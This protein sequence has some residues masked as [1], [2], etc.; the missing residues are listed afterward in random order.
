MR[1]DGKIQ[2]GVTLI[3]WKMGWSLLRVAIL[4]STYV[5]VL[6]PSNLAGGLVITESLKRPKVSNL[7]LCLGAKNI[8][9]NLFN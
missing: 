1:S 3:L 6:E 7:N 2:D 5:D 4:A 9:K 8:F